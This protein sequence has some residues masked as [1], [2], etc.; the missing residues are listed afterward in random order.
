MN[1][2]HL[3]T[4]LQVASTGSLTGAA[5]ALCLSQPAISHHIKSLEED[6]GVRLFIRHKKGM[7]LTVE[8]EELRSACRTVMRAADDISFQVQQINGL[9]RGKVVVTLTSFMGSALTPAILAFK[10]EYPLVQ[11][12]MVF[13]NTDKVLDRLK[14]NRADLG[15]AA[16]SP[17]TGVPVTGRLVHRERILLLA[18]ADHSLCGRTTITPADLREHLFVT[19]ETGTFTRQFTEDWF[20]DIPMPA[21]TIET[22]RSNSVR[23]LILAGAVGLAPENVMIRDIAEGKVAVLPAG[24]LRPWVECS[25]YISRSRPL[26]KAARAF[27]ETLCAARCLSD[28]EGL[29]G[30]LEALC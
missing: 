12:E 11:V 8:G 4:F 2:G 18:P 30:W 9:K 1:L 24:G 17:L 19:R 21:N 22:T 14:E 27:L 13:N 5:Q 15:F 20:G 7:Q 26:S 10:R 16:S 25:V 28:A 29:P 3:T 23:D 6:L